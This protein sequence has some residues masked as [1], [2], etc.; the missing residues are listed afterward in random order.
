VQTSVPP[1][2]DPCVTESTPPPTTPT[3]VQEVTT[4]TTRLTTTTSSSSTTTSL[5][6]EV[7][8]VEIEQTTTTLPTEVKGEELARTGPS[9][10]GNLI[11]SA[12]IALAVGGLS[13]VFG[14]LVRNATSS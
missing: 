4:T 3:T 5:V 7:Q 12:V 9:Y 6:T 10:T 11:A 8:G 2:E 13:L 14:R 1:G